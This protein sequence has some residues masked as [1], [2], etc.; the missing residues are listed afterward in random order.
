MSLNPLND[1]TIVIE[2]KTPKD[3]APLPSQLGFGLHTSA[4]FIS[5]PLQVQPEK[6]LDPLAESG[7]IPFCLPRVPF[8]TLWQQP[9]WAPSS[10]KC[11][12][13]GSL[14]HSTSSINIWWLTGGEQFK[15]LH[16]FPSAIWNGRVEMTSIL[17]SWSN[18]GHLPDSFI[19]P[20]R[21]VCLN[22]CLFPSYKWLHITQ[23]QATKPS[24]IPAFS[25]IL[26]Y[27]SHIHTREGW[28]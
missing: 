26:L 13:G 5:P 2:D 19:A 17:V 21:G 15:E 9:I 20:P 27:M 25:P 23:V 11:S 3:L 1:W 16:E 4:L 6:L 14:A 12:H 18:C 7:Y 8:L 28:V 10:Y 22:L 24:E